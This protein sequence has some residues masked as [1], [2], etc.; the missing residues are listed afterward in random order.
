[1]VMQLTPLPREAGAAVQQPPPLLQLMARALVAVRLPPLL[2][3]ARALVTVR[4]P[5]LLQATQAV[6][7]QLPPGQEAWALALAVAY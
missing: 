2:Q 7:Q 6:V 1:M 3:G 5:P 4:L